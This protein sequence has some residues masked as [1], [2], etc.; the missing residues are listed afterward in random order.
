M[1]ADGRVRLLC[2]AVLLLCASFPAL[3]APSDV[4]AVREL[5]ETDPSMAAY[6]SEVDALC[7]PFSVLAV[8]NIPLSLLENV[9]REGVSK[10]VSAAALPAALVAEAR[11]LVEAKGILAASGD[12][13][14]PVSRQLFEE[15]LRRLSLVL[16][17][18]VSPEVATSILALSG[19]IGRGLTFG[20]TLLAILQ[21]G[22][23]DSRE[24]VDLARSVLASSLSPASYRALPPLFVRARLRGLGMSETASLI[25]RLLS[26]GFGII[27]IEAEIRTYARMP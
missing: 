16:Q 11:R 14:A 10:R 21:V 7:A 24:T 27:Q 19:E 8:Q 13:S 1:I 26:R 3:A 9:L 23:L 15:R 4:A 25:E 17:G 18:G 22:P 20:E 2:I 6:R 12:R 5:I